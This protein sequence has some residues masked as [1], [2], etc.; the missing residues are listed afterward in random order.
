MPKNRRKNR[1]NM[2]NKKSDESKNESITKLNVEYTDYGRETNYLIKKEIKKEMQNQKEKEKVEGN[3]KE[4]N[5]KFVEDK[6]NKEDIKLIK[7]KNNK[8]EIDMKEKILEIEETEKIHI[9]DNKFLKEE[10]LEKGKINEYK[11]NSSNQITSDKLFNSNIN[12]DNSANTAI[13]KKRLLEINEEIEKELGDD[14]LIRTGG[15]N[16]SSPF[17]EN[18]IEIKI[19][20]D[21]ISFMDSE[22]D[23]EKKN[24]IKNEKP[25]AAQKEALDRLKVVLLEEAKKLENNTTGPKKEHTLKIYQ[26][27]QPQKAQQYPVNIKNFTKEGEVQNLSVLK[28]EINREIEKTESDGIKNPTLNTDKNIK[29]HNHTFETDKNIKLQNHTFKS[30]INIVYTNE[31]ENVE[32]KKKPSGFKKFLKMF[33]CGC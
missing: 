4:E 27:Y 23:T 20:N 18:N 26:P 33:S 7:E 3:E 1:K 17:I 8:E 2:I 13:L 28:E 12:S 14:L 24:S 6:N 31:I 11:N 10:N 9:Y 29:A 22:D 19:E 25:F 5:T 30:D 32:D 21:R 15:I 16:K